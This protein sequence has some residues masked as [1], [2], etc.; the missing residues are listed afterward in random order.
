MADIQLCCEMICLSLTNNLWLN[1]DTSC[2]EPINQITV[3]VVL[4]K[5]CYL[6]VFQRLDKRF[7]SVR[8]WWNWVSGWDYQKIIIIK[9]KKKI[10]QSTCSF[11]LF[12]GILW[13]F[14]RELDENI[15]TTFQNVKLFLLSACA[16]S[17]DD[18]SKSIFYG[19]GCKSIKEH[20]LHGGAVSLLHS[21]TLA[22][23]KPICQPCR[24]DRHSVCMGAWNLKWNWSPA[25]LIKLHSG[26]FDL[27]VLVTFV[28]KRCR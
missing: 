23:N 7:V 28:S 19:E 25:L 4:K 11:W 6:Y 24:G 16:S 13:H 20:C 5:G 1:T 8:A 27:C 26:S 22:H 14:G 21:R 12:K 17:K 18:F 15:N 10:T 9:K 2:R 3:T